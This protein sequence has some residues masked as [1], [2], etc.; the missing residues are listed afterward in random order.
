[1]KG[2]IW[3]GLFFLLLG[4]SFILHQA[5]M[6]DVVKIIST[7]WPF[8]F[9]IIGVIQLI[10]RTYSSVI[11]GLLFFLMG[12]LFLA[13]EWYDVNLF[14]YALPLIF[15]VIGFVIIFSRKKYDIITH[16]TGELSSFTL[17]GAADVKSRSKNLKGGSILN[18]LGSSEIDLR[19]AVISDKA[20]IDLNC[21]LGGVTVI[22][23]ENVRVNISGIPILGAWEDLTKGYRDDKDVLDLRINCQV[24]LGGVEFRN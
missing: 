11:A 23:P 13:N 15:I 3:L 18:I 6:I 10:N 12:V 20:T 4:V 19:E 7:G 5:N 2:R 16:S 21:V 22:V 24:V 1:M 8:I 17:L 14:P 9:I